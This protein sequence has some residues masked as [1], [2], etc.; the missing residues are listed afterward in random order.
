[1]PFSYRFTFTGH[2]SAEKEIFSKDVMQTSASRRNAPTIGSILDAIDD[3]HKYGDLA[4]DVESVID[5]AAQRSAEIVQTFAFPSMPNPNFPHRL[6]SM[7]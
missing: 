2:F 1:M 7:S 6:P 4:L 5:L 3:A